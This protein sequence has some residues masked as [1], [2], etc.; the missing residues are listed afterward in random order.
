M[1]PL[2]TI[3]AGEYLVAEHIER[4]FPKWRVWIPS[5]DTGVD[6]LVTGKGN[7][8]AVSLQVKFSKDFDSSHESPIGWWN[9]EAKK[10]RSSTADFWVFVLTS[11]T[12]K[13]NYIIVSPDELLR[14]FKAIHGRNAKRIHS[15]LCVIKTKHG[16]QCWDVRNLANADYDLIESGR[17]REKDR[18]FTK[19]LN[20]WM[21]IDRRLR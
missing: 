10:I 13:P 15:Y 6:L 9:Y 20:G 12:Q 3:H 17:F 14:R 18:N 7:R 21:Q 19:Y 16:L 11:F 2:F 8:K 5:K 4:T 1:R